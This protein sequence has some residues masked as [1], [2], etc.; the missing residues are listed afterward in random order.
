[1]KLDLFGILKMK[2]KKTSDEIKAKQQQIS[3][4]EKQIPHSLSDSQAK[5]D[6]LDLSPVTFCYHLGFILIPF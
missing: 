3:S 1:M 5:V 6:K 4:L 2:M